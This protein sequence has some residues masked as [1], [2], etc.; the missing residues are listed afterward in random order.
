M[1]NF[2][3]DSEGRLEIYHPDTGGYVLAASPLA[4]P[5]GLLIALIPEQKT[6][7]DQISGQLQI[8]P[9]ILDQVAQIQ[10]KLTPGS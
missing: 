9:Q 3:T 10:Q 8:L 7:L 5:S 4:N 2:R 6:S 1:T